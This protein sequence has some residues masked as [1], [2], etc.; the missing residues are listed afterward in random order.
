VKDGAAEVERWRGWRGKRTGRRRGRWRA[1]RRVALGRGACAKSGLRKQGKGSRSR[2]EGRLGWQEANWASEG[3]ASEG[4][5]SE[6]WAL[7]GWAW[8]DMDIGQ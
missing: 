4:W 3:W 8:A 1:F 7:K 2:R 6:G 5:A